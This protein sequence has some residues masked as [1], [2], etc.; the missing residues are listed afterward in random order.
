MGTAVVDSTHYH[1]LYAAGLVLLV[2]LVLI[3]VG[4]GLLRE[5]VLR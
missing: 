1:A 4:I 3:N 5:K 2:L